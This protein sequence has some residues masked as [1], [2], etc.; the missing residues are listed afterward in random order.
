[1]FTYN[2]MPVETIYMNGADVLEGNYQPVYNLKPE[3]V[4]KL[5]ITEKI[6]NQI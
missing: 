6:V 3:N 4:E 5:E 1:M 2:G